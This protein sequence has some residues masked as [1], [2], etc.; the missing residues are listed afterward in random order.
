MGYARSD[1]VSPTPTENSFNYR[2]SS[3]SNS[4]WSAFQQMQQQYP[5]NPADN[6]FRQHPTVQN[7]DANKLTSS[8]LARGVET[9]TNA[10]MEHPLYAAPMCVAPE[11]TDS[12]STLVP[13]NAWSHEEPKIGVDSLKQPNHVKAENARSPDPQGNAF[14]AQTAN[15]IVVQ[16]TQMRPLSLS[17]NSGAFSNALNRDSPQPFVNIPRVKV[18]GPVELALPIT[19]KH[20]SVASEIGSQKG[21]DSSTASSRRRDSSLIDAYI[22]TSRLSIWSYPGQDKATAASSILDR[23]DDD[24]RS[25]STRGGWG[26]NHD[27][28]SQ[29]TK[30]VPSSEHPRMSMLWPPTTL[31][32]HASRL[33]PWSPQNRGGSGAHSSRS[34]KVHWSDLQAGG[35]LAKP[36]YSVSTDAIDEQSPTSPTDQSNLFDLNEFDEQKP[37]GQWS[38]LWRKMRGN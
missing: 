30:E 20:Y 16:T 7:V 26:G 25:T 5:P 36:F 37:S 15:S 27:D 4:T 11:K 14:K 29:S 21:L 23:Y 31:L 13:G 3:N 2:Y 17:R 35:A 10:R 1:C 8:P 19:I 32:Q 18:S 22:Q 28:G 33:A 38:S 34:S 9:A 24:E 12:Q 6:I